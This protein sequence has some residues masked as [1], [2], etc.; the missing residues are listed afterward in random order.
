MP[1]TPAGKP[2]NVAPVAPVVAYVILV[3][4]VLI[5]TVCALVPAADVKVTVLAGVTVMDP[6]AVIAPQPPVS[7]TV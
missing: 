5:V 1:L 7:V 3:M 6:V 4:G 2:V